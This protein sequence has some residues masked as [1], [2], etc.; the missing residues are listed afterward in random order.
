ML[1]T[2]RLL[3]LKFLAGVTAG[4]YVVGG[5]VNVRAEAHGHFAC[6]LRGSAVSIGVPAL[7]ASVD[8]LLLPS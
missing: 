5:V 8:R 3:R 7:S 1:V 6:G 2:L 4:K